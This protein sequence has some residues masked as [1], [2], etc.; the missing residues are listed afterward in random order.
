[1]VALLYTVMHVRD[2]PVRTRS[3]KWTNLF[4]S[5]FIRFVCLMNQMTRKKICSFWAIVRFNK[6]L[7][8]RA[9]TKAAALHL[10][11]CRLRTCFSVE[12]RT[13][14]KWLKVDKSDRSL[15]SCNLINQK[16]LNTRCKQGLNDDRIFGFWVTVG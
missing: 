14:Q 15:T 13:E 9:E 6:I 5:Q 12:I 11:F 7:A 1:M 16:Y 10:F 8:V 2:S 3:S 4:P